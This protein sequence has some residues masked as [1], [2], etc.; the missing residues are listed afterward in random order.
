MHGVLSLVAV[1]AGVAI[2][3]ASMSGFRSGEVV[4]RPITQDDAAFNLVLCRRG[5]RTKSG[6]RQLSSPSPLCDSQNVS[7]ALPNGI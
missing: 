3:P 6:P 1:E 4:Y 5:I 2:V 7:P